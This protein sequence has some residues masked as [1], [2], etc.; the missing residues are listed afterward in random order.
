MR[1]KQD[2]PDA[3]FS[4][5]DPRDGDHQARSAFGLIEAPLGDK[6]EWIDARESPPINP[7]PP[8]SRA[9]KRVSRIHRSPNSNPSVFGQFRSQGLK[10][11]FHAPREASDMNVKLVLAPSKA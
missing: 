2:E 4:K 9:V 7:T 11:L 5:L 1:S 3:P 10:R 6:T 8:Q